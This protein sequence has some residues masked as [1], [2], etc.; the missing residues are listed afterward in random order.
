MLPNLA[1]LKITAVEP[2]STPL[3][4]QTNDNHDSYSEPPFVLAEDNEMQSLKAEIKRLLTSPKTDGE[5]PMIT[6]EREALGKTIEAMRAKYSQDYEKTIEAVRAKYSQDYKQAIDDA[7]SK[8]ATMFANQMRA[9]RALAEERERMLRR[10]RPPRS[11]SRRT[12]TGGTA[13]HPSNRVMMASPRRNNNNKC[14][15][16]LGGLTIPASK[17]PTPT[18]HVQ[19]ILTLTELVVEPLRAMR[20]R[21]INAFVTAST[22][23]VE[24]ILA[25]EQGEAMAHD[26]IYHHC[27]HRIG[28]VLMYDQY[29]LK[30]N[31]PDN[32]PNLNWR[33][34]IFNGIEKRI[35][36]PSMSVF[37]WAY[38]TEKEAADEVADVMLRYD[39]LR[40]AMDI[41]ADAC[42]TMRGYIN[43]YETDEF[44]A[45]V[46]DTGFD[47][48]IASVH[49]LWIGSRNFMDHN[50]QEFE[51][52]CTES[53][54]LGGSVW[55]ESVP[56]TS[57]VPILL[58]D[59]TRLD[60]RAT[61]ARPDTLL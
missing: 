38:N 54:E 20:A 15:D 53:I 49:T 30:N 39:D 29:L 61:P 36:I 26:V 6:R 43:D 35:V 40:E 42:V 47:A 14:L 57:E 2:S 9:A 8:L 60:P 13:L 45:T 55:L 51:N 19:P 46:A 56:L 48:S 28:P 22:I 31:V 32:S 27:E 37:G 44:Q 7:A 41:M 17:T 4:T 34:V 24:F 23:A 52:R 58:A 11:P 25:Q 16:D 3:S 50:R 1:H 5:N 10:N 59:G 21:W 33:H 18:G 12:V